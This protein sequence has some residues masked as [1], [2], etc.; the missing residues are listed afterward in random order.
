M[1]EPVLLRSGEGARLELGAI[2][3]GWTKIGSKE[4]DDALG[5]W[6]FS[7]SGGEGGP[8]PHVHDQ[9]HEVM[10]LLEGEGEFLLGER[11]ERIGPGA[12]L[13]APPGTV[14]GVS[15]TSDAVR[16]LIVATPAST[17]EGVID[18][19]MKMAAAG[20]PDPQKMAEIFE[21]VDIEL[22]G[23]PPA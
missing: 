19:M 22:A 23:P 14:H 10:V 4:T 12:F 1:T 7:V 20:P 9:I 5:A 13:Y 8:P 15:P 11:T 21:G 17:H 3:Q 6:E 16:V 18:A 2:G